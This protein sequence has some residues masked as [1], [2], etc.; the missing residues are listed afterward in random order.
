MRELLTRAW[1][2]LVGRIDGPLAFRLILQP[3]A[4]AFLAIRAG[5]NDARSGHAAYGWAI[6]TDPIRRRDLL[7]HGFKEI[8]KVFVVAVII[9]LAYEIIVFRAIYLG[10]SLIVAVAVA[11]LPYI[12]IRGPINRIVRRWRLGHRTA[13]LTDHKGRVHS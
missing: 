6:V 4:A 13:T 11:L 3:T 5:L 1:E 7:Q 2:D 10:Q 12:M 8:A 9:D